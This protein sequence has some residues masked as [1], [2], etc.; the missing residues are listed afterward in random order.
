LT[1]LLHDFQE[2][3]QVIWYDS[4]TTEG[5]LKWQDQLNELNYE[6][7]NACDG[8]FTNYTWK[9][10]YP[11]KSASIAGN[12]RLDVY[13]GIDVFGRNTF[14]GG[15]MTCNKALDV[16]KAAGLSA[17]L[18]A[19]G[20]VMQDQM[21]SGG[22][23]PSG[24]SVEAWNSIE[25][26]FIQKNDE[27][28][29]LIRPYFDWNSVAFSNNRLLTFFNQGAGNQFWTEGQ[30]VY[31]KDFFW[32]NLS[33]Q[34]PD[35]VPF[36]AESS[37][38]NC[39]I[40]Y[41]D[42]FEGGSCLAIQGILKLGEIQIVPL[43]KVAMEQGEGEMQLNATYKISTCSKIQLLLI[44]KDSSSKARTEKVISIDQNDAGS[45][46]L[47][48]TK[49]SYLQ[50]LSKSS[51]PQGDWLHSSF[52]LSEVEVGLVEIQLIC[53][54]INEEGEKDTSRGQI[55]EF[56]CFLGSLSYGPKCPPGE[57]KN[58]R[59][60]GCTLDEST[61]LASFMLLWDFDEHAA[62]VDVFFAASSEHKHNNNFT[63]LGR[64]YSN[65]YQVIAANPSTEFH[66][67]KVDLLG[68]RQDRIPVCVMMAQTSS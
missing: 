22:V 25:H 24:A 68:C 31:S 20:W 7:F 63:W 57:L 36:D 43:F 27:F 53:A 17:A 1:S 41:N 39:T 64:S 34:S 30:E 21:Q 8:I 18:F 55:S 3:S 15:G 50:T 32:Y 4:V 67:Q 12:R 2:E 5:E 37:S 62:F 46:R 13:Y 49:D 56:A 11:A 66:I 65:R 54:C 44:F 26:E 35:M 45:T 47:V 51:K 60:E 28:W 10:D 42:A 40:N 59:V 52:S 23:F 9:E 16:I 29:K 58:V 6:Y 48:G 61:G 33:M 19:P 38:I 14:G